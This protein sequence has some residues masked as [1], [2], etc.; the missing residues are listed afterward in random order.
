MCIL[1]FQ[2]FWLFPGALKIT[3][4][5]GRSNFQIHI[6]AILIADSDS[7]QKSINANYSS[8]LEIQAGTQSKMPKTSENRVSSTYPFFA[9]F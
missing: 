6:F 5:Y 4:P 7:S 9:S 8:F 2:K 3:Y 1:N